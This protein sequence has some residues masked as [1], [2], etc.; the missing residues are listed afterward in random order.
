MPSSKVGFLMVFLVSTCKT[1]HESELCDAVDPRDAKKKRKNCHGPF[2]LTMSFASATSR[3]RR[4]YPAPV[5]TLSCFRFFWPLLLF[6]L[7]QCLFTSYRFVTAHVPGVL[8]AGCGVMV[9][10]KKKQNRNVMWLC[11]EKKKMHLLTY[12]L[13][14]WLVPQA[15]SYLLPIG[16]VQLSGVDLLWVFMPLGPH[17]LNSQLKV[18]QHSRRKGPCQ[19]WQTW[20]KPASVLHLFRCGGYSWGL[21][22]FQPL[23]LN[24]LMGFAVDSVSQTCWCFAGT[25]GS[26]RNLLV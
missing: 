19:D 3:H 22:W 17:S 16:K 1:A 4:K 26:S 24:K 13:C 20:A 23:Y 5:R 14:L 12:V 6:H 8:Q 18:S 7:Q 21:V 25:R 11:K 9:P 15:V 2:L 10:R